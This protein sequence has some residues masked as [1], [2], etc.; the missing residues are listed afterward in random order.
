M[1]KQA[2]EGMSTPR[3]VRLVAVTRMAQGCVASSPEKERQ[4]FNFSNFS[5]IANPLKTAMRSE[6]NNTSIEL[7]G[8]W[9]QPIN[10]KWSVKQRMERC[11]AIGCA[12]RSP[13]EAERVSSLGMYIHS[14]NLFH[15]LLASTPAV[16]HS[17]TYIGWLPVLVEFRESSTQYSSTLTG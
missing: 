8:Y 9:K 4:I 15:F 1:T 17:Y 7:G 16:P 2:G 11:W 12:I 14:I 13:E 3:G 6:E 10:L 5:K